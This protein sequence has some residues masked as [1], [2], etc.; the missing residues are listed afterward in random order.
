MKVTK[1]EVE[2]LMGLERLVVEPGAFTI[3]EG[4]NAVGKT[5][6]LEAVRAIATEGHDPSLLRKGAERGFVRLTL[7]DGSVMQKTVTEK[8]SSFEGRHPKLGK[9]SKARA[10]VNELVDELGID[11]LALITC[12]PVKR[13]EYLE[14][15]MSFEV[16]R[17]D[18]EA[19]AGRTMTGLPLASKASGLDLVDAGRKALYDERTGLN[20]VAKEKRA[21]AKQL[22]ETLPPAGEEAPDLALL[23]ARKGMGEAALA[24][25]E[26]ALRETMQAALE[27]IRAN[28]QAEIDGVRADVTERIR[29]L[30]RERETALAEIKG[31]AERFAEAARVA[32]ADE[33][34]TVTAKIAPELE[35][36]TAQ[37][38]TA[39]ALEREH[40][41]AEKTREILAQAEKDATAAEAEAK[42][43]T[44]GIEGLDALRD[45]LLA[46][47]PVAGL[48]VRE[49]M[50]YVDGLPFERVNSARQIEV[51]LEVARLRVKDVPL[52]VSDHGEALD[53]ANWAALETKAAALGMNLIVA[54]R[55]EGPLAV[56]TSS[57]A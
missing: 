5:S 38:A 8:A 25:S 13:A 35:G 52:L 53:A 16:S 20:R 41:R 21:T 26:K 6:F 48:E 29:A 36:L 12:P 4:A 43:L 22:G 45:K 33:M 57:A 15:L 17:K 49:G 39:E 50:V 28:A 24:A 54:R 23:R 27:S 11:P 14:G 10:W 31:Q 1:I 47:C 9:V 3:I 32:F 7:D 55:T 56:R 34:K 51:C 2:N 30:E 44:A 18:I 42:V 40:V 37:I 19:A 46:S